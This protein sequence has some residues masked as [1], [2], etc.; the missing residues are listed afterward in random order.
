[1]TEGRGSDAV[2]CVILLIA[3]LNKCYKKSFEGRGGKRLLSS[4]SNV[5]V[6]NTLLALFLLWK[7]YVYFLIFS[8][9]F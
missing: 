8:V 6:C 9:S 3:L 7:V 1:V 2:L 4:I 5:L